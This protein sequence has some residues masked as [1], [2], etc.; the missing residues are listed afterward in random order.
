MSAGLIQ[1]LSVHDIDDCECDGG[2]RKKWKSCNKQDGFA[3][4]MDHL[5]LDDSTALPLGDA[6]GA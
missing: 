6:S 1:K 3:L 5:E 2:C 4:T